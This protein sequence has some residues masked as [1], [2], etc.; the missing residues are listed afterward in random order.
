[1]VTTRAAGVDRD[2]VKGRKERELADIIDQILDDI[3]D[4]SAR[5][6]DLEV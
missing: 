1:M 4:I 6:D 2:Q 5:V 3:I